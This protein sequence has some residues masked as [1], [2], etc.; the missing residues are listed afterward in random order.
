MLKLAQQRMY[1]S[2]S[3]RVDPTQL[4]LFNDAEASSDGAGEPE[5]GPAEPRFRRRGGPR[6]V[7]LSKLEVV[8]V[9]HELPEGDRAC[10]QCGE[11]MVGAG[12]EVTRKLRM[13]PAHLVV[14][15]HRVRKYRC[16]ACCGANAAGDE[17]TRAIIVRA[18]RPPEAFPR[19]LCTPSLAA[20]AIDQKYVGAE[21]LYRSEH[22]LAALGCPISRADLCNWVLL[23]W[24]RWL[25]WVRDAMRGYVLGREVLHADETRCRC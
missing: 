13:V 6:R 24:E 1:G 10:P 21:P 9:E 12:V 16:D 15:E 5:E 2:R 7:D 18:P 8:V 3:E 23:A 11:P 25:V 20:W 17:G 19:S 14:E 22:R 4:M